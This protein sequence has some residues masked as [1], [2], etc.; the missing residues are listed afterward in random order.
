MPNSTLGFNSKYNIDLRTHI[1]FFQQE[2][3]QA[4][5]SNLRLTPNHDKQSQLNQAVN[6]NM[7]IESQSS[8]QADGPG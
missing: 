3:K 6:T 7:A 2:N 5:S 1:N 8:W 4:Q